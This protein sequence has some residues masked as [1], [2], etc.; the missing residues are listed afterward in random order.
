MRRLAIILM[1]VGLFVISC[2]KE[3]DTY[4]SP[5]TSIE[6]VYLKNS[7]FGDCFSGLIVDDP[8][9]IVITTDEQYQA[10]GDSCRA[11]WMS[12]VMCDTANLPDID[13]NKYSLIGKYVAGGGCDVVIDNN[14][15][16]DTLNLKYIYS[17]HNT[18]EG[19]CEM[20]IMN[21]NWALVPAIPGNYE[22]EFRVQRDS[23]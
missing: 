15:E 17:I 21:M 18:F 10:L 6:A 20:F 3:K 5:D 7:H 16:I 1:T 2:E 8:D 22:V 11:L 23:Q 9:G 14:L 13:F 12:S 19:I 4:K